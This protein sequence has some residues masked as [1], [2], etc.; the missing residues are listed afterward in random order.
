MKI[1]QFK[2]APMLNHSAWEPEHFKIKGLV[3]LKTA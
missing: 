3:W 1:I 2:P